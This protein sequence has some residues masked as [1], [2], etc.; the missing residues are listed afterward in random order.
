MKIVK[1]DRDGFLSN[2]VNVENV[3]KWNKELTL[4]NDEIHELE[5]LCMVIDTY[6]KVVDLKGI[7]AQLWKENV[8]KIEKIVKQFLVG[9][10]EYDLKFV[11]TGSEVILNITKNGKEMSF[12]QCSGYEK[13]ILDIAFKFSLR[14]LCF[15]PKSNFIFIDEGFDCFDSENKAKIQERGGVL[16]V[17]K[18][19]Y[20][21]VNFITQLGLSHICDNKIEIISE[22]PKISTISSEI[23]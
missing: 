2:W 4:F 18:N 5:S 7:P 12:Y 10:V 22:T 3:K 20:H 13:L 21:N 15:L 8:A 1:K 9:K 17:L 14:K 23:S 6:K 16:D 11:C 19:E